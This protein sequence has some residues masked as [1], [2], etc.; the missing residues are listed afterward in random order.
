MI[1]ETQKK[2]KQLLTKYFNKNNL[3]YPIMTK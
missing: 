3:I 2:K 1:L